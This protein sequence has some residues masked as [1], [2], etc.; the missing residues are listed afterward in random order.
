[1]RGFTLPELL[2]AMLLTM[3][4]TGA[5]FLVMQPAQSILHAQLET[6][7]LQQRLRYAVDALARDLVMAA[8]VLPYR[9]GAVDDDPAA[10]VFYRP[11]TVTA[12]YVP[13]GQ[14]ASVSHTYYLRADAATGAFQLMHYDGGLGDFPVVDHVLELGFNYL[15]VAADGVSLTTLDEPELIDGP[16]VPDAA[17]PDRYDIDLRRIRRVRVQLRL[18]VGQPSLRGPAG[19]LFQRGGSATSVY[20]YVPDRAIRF[21][22][23]PR[24]V[25]MP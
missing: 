22:L 13:P 18:Q 10:G 19:A 17:A 6:A 16:W 8:E 9:V 24:N 3:V 1:V 15:G 14:A 2:I 4:V 12:R 5:V 21:D 20:R 11:D 25:R 23:S 7:D